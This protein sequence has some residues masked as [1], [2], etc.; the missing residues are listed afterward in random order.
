M[1][2]YPHLFEPVT[3]GSVTLPNRVIMGSMHTGMEDDPAQFPE[4]AAYF[5]ERVRGGAVLMVTGGFSPDEAGVLYPGGGR[6]TTTAEAAEHHVITSAVH[7]AGGKILLQLLHAGRYAAHEGAVAPSSSQAPINRYHA[8]EMTPGQ[9]DRTVRD[10]GRAAELAHQA[11]YD[12]V[13]IMGSEGYLLNQFL[14]ERTNHRVD[15][16]GGDPERRRR[17]PV[18]VAEAVKTAVPAE[19]LV[20]YRISLQD[21]VE[22]GQS[23]PDVV[24]LARDLERA[25]VDVFNTGIGWHEA[26]VPTIVTSVPRAAF[27]Q[28]TGEL[29]AA[30]SVPVVASNRINIPETAEEILAAGQAD[31]ISMARPFLADPEWVDKAG[32]GRADQIN[33]CIACNQACL[34][35][36][37]AHKRATCL[38]NPRAGNETSLILSP[39]RRVKHIAVIG[40]GPAGLSCAVSLARRGHRVDLFEAQDHLG[41]QFAL[42]QRIPGKEEFSETIRYF[43]RQLELTGVSVHLSTTVDAN[44]LAQQD[45]DEV[46]L[47]TG[48]APRVPAIDGLDHSSVMTYPELLSGRRVAGQSVA[49][50]GAGGIGVDVSEFLTHPESP[51]LDLAA[52][53]AE[54]GVAGSDTPGGLGPA[55]PAPSPREV[56]LVQ[57]RATPIGKDLGL[58]SGWVHRASLKH[59]G[60]RMIPAA[61]YERIDD[62][63]LHLTVPVDPKDADAGRAEITLPVD[64][65]VV[66]AGQVSRNDLA[67]P[68]R[69]RGLAVHVIGGADVAAELDAKRAIGQGTRLA[70]EL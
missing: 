64:T 44:S 20:M 56:V 25:G 61:T 63:G 38:V 34:D 69:E 57:R 19:F 45:F 47:A 14:A 36:T 37:F 42:A 39:A 68:L 8:A 41:G 51:S 11:G 18:A 10:F 3:L 60:V 54:W 1:N 30:V 65:V 33:T 13:E 4:L 15:E 31:L 52:W 53:R 59:K 28:V 43:T 55:S 24:A 16:W 49:V 12:G 70:A 5:A 22:G 2:A 46:V 26:R 17:F 48:V 62:D 29:K 32:S 66:C 21:L 67:A 6:I 35:H 23:W 27:A 58:T 50:I 7:Q 40:A 9:I